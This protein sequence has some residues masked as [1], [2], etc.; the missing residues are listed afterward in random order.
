MDIEDFDGR[1]FSKIFS[2]PGYINIHAPGIEIV[3]VNPDCL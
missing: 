1:V 2:K 3:I